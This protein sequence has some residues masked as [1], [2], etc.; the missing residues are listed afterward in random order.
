MGLHYGGPRSHIRPLHFVWQEKERARER[1][2]KS[3]GEREVG[4]EESRE[5]EVSEKE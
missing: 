4:C 2:M 1:R 3:E 5:G